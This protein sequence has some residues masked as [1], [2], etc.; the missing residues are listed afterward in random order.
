MLP[1]PLPLATPSPL[2]RILALR[3]LS[4]A[5]MTMA[6][7]VAPILLDLSIRPWPLLAIAFGLA[8]INLVSQSDSQKGKLS[9]PLV[10]TG[11]LVTDLAA[12]GLYAYLSGGTTNPLI[13]LM[14]PI[15]AVGAMVLT[16][17]M[18]WLLAASA[19]AIYALVWIYAPPL[20]VR[21]P[22]AG[23]WW[24]LAGMAMTFGMSAA[25]VTAF[26]SRLST[27]LRAR[28][29]AL[30]QAREAQLRNERIVAL[31][32]LAA[33]TAHE[34]GTPLGTLKLLSGELSKLPDIP[35]NIHEDL[36]LMDQQVDRCRGILQALA[37]RSGNL[38]AEGGCTVRLGPW[39]RDLIE[40]CKK[41]KPL[42]TLVLKIQAPAHEFLLVADQT[43]HQ[44]IAN[45][46]N[47]A[48]E[49]DPRGAALV[50]A[51]LAA[52]GV[53]LRVVDGGPGF[54]PPGEQTASSF[55]GMGV[56]LSLADLAIGRHGGTLN[57]KKN[58]D[59]GTIAQVY[60]P[61]EQRPH[62]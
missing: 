29:A 28:E 58:P 52:G 56:G 25:V 37:A 17:Q 39:L 50:T 47:N 62:D 55:G 54:D 2:Q 9:T 31:A 1:R 19:I 59:G 60:L 45:L 61:T 15:A 13:S 38:R 23:V 49:A 34:L 10:M 18:A 42:A 4:I 44:A 51:E 12:W 3:W 36:L 8:L 41:D 26:I 22:A 43:L 21:D 35:P 16:Q 6:A 27:T 24:H 11:H 46:I 53:T 7:L 48:S 5:V 32:N 57:F 30:A 14:L 20:T 40:S 33:G